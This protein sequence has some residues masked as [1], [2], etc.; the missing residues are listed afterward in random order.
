M[1]EEDVAEPPRNFTLEQLQFFNGSKDEK[2]KD[3]EVFLAL[4]GI[5][6]DVSKGRDFYG[7]GGPYA[8][9]A[10]HECG[11][12]LAKMSFEPQHLDNIEGCKNL[13]FGE[14]TE[15]ENWITK[16]RD[17]RSYPVK[18]RLVI[19]M[20]D[21][22]QELSL[23]DL[24]K[25]NGKGEL[26]E[27]Y[28]ASP[29]YIGANGRVFDMS[30]GGVTFYGEGCPYNKF[31]GRDASRALGKMS[32]DEVDLDNYSIEDFTEKE[33][34]IMNDWIKTFEERKKYPVVGILKHNT[35]I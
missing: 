28:A 2:D 34:K 8:A 21:P 22:N 11:M 9:F 15:L 24:Q 26:P 6:F 5:V 10:G 35:A 13:S 27:G 18:G 12:A 1:E 17:Y 29:I 16:F 32:L 31:A 25:C 30:F 20:P 19:D 4:N 14:R 23:A 7:P 33:L 3:K